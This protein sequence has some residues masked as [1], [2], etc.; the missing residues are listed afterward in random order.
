MAGMTRRR[1]LLAT[2][3]LA[4][5]AALAQRPAPVTALRAANAL[6]VETG[7]LIPHAVVLVRGRRIA[8]IGSDLAVPAGARVVDLGALTL[9][10]GMIDAHVHLF[11]HPGNET[12]QTVD[13]STPQRTI[14]ATLAAK[15]DLLGG[16]TA[17]KDMGTEGA[18][19]VASTAVRQAINR[20]EIPGPRVWVCGNAISILGGHEDAFG[21]NPAL[22]IPSN[23]DVVQ[24]RRDL[25]HTIRL[26]IKDGATFIKIYQ[27]GRDRFADGVFSTPYQFTEP[28]LAAAVREAARLGTFVSVHAQGEPGTL[29]AAQAGVASIDHATQ[30]SPETMRLMVAKHIFAVPTFTVFKFFADH[31]PNPRSAANQYAELAYKAE[32]FRIQ[33]KAGVPMV[34]GSDVGPFP[35]GTQ[36]TEFVLMVHYGMAP[37][38]A[39]QAGTINAA[40][41][42]RD[43]ANL[44][45]LT[46]GK[47]ADIIAVQGNPLHD[48]SALTRVRFVMKG[49][50]IYKQ[51]PAN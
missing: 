4:L 42:L 50:K 44:G 9:M 6:V 3:A 37:L 45:S 38:E 12:L 36:A 8:A 5:T 29:Y 48:I 20:G 17:V 11:L 27:T 31:A 16:F 7:Q 46:P 40:T 23:A 13:E 10:P 28:Q 22:H 24:T 39:I 1:P 33:L 14:Q 15:A 18:G 34:M 49:G 21:F 32:Q 43:Q 26:Q 35:H 30:L 47:Y 19:D 25:I 51:P 41:L 2:L